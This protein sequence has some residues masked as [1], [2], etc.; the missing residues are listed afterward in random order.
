MAKWLS[1]LTLISLVAPSVNQLGFTTEYIEK[2]TF[3]ELASILGK[4]IK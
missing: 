1:Q 4:M 3:V 2:N